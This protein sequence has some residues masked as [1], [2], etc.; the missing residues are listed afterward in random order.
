[1]NLQN[2][3]TAKIDNKS[4]L[5]IFVITLMPVA[6]F[7]YAIIKNPAYELAGFEENPVGLPIMLLVALAFPLYFG[8][9]YF[10][11]RVKLRINEKG[12]WTAKAGQVEWAD[13]NT[14][15]FLERKGRR[16][17]EVF[18]KIYL[19]DL[20]TEVS[21]HINELDRSEQC[22]TKVLEFYCKDYPVHFL[23][24]EVVTLTH[25]FKDR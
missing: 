3:L 12:I 16:Y 2:E 23:E 24:R 21:V 10:D 18:L 22:I 9:R 4:Y 8:V 20:D 13:I 11:R 14:I 7:T 25:S 6:G 1:M 19:N 17:S 5:L 15:C